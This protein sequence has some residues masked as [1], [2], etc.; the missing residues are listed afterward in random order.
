MKKQ[1]K[2]RKVPNKGDGE[3]APDDYIQLGAP[4]VEHL[5]TEFSTPL[6]RRLATIMARMRVRDI[7]SEIEGVWPPERLKTPDQVAIAIQEI[8]FSNYEDQLL[9]LIGHRIPV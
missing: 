1:P 2:M 4:A 5:F 3:Y 6:E 7:F 9:K 8:L